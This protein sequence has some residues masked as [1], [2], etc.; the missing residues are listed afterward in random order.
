MI[1]RIKDWWLER[2]S[3]Q[4]WKEMQKTMLVAPVAPAPPNSFAFVSD[5]KTESAL[6]LTVEGEEV[7]RFKANGQVE[8]MKEDVYD[9]AAAA[10]VNS[11]QL[12]IEDSSGIIRTRREW[13]ERML[14]ALTSEAEK[15]GS[16]NAE[17]LTNVVKKCIM[18][19]RLK[20]TAT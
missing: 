14:K 3:K 20:G 13:E 16:L 6:T 8:W 4:I 7:M 11:L 9:E 1:N 5:R 12:R 18:Y 19:D 2:Q 10:F 15:S 17:E